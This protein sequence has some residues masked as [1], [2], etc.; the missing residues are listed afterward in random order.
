VYILR[1]HSPENLAALAQYC[2]EFLVHGVDV[3]GKRC[4]IEETLVTLLGEHSPI[5]VTYGKCVRAHGYFGIFVNGD[6]G[7]LVPSFATAQ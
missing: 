3:E 2:T 4:G 6:V 1:K 5:P 7:Q